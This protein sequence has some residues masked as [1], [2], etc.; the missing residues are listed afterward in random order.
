MSDLLL[1]TN[2]KEC[3]NCRCHGRVSHFNQCPQCGT[4]IFL[5]RIDF[6]GYEADG[7]SKEWWLFTI[8]KGWMHRSHVMLGE[9]PLDRRTPELVTT[10]NTKTAEERIAEVRADTN[11][12]IKSITP[13]RNQVGYGRSVTHLSS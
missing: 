13:K 8:E 12:K 2:K 3:P 5:R 6:S 11:E 10:K 1:L 7:H 9:Q 4:M